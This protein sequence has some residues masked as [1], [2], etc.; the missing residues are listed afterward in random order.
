MHLLA[1]R[2]LSVAGTLC[3]I[4]I[5][6]EMSAS[7]GAKTMMMQDQSRANCWPIFGG[8][9]TAANRTLKLKSYLR[10][11]RHDRKRKW[12]TTD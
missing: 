1:Q 10:R 5:R 3:D 8:L 11:L 7:R 6:P 4:V 9:R 12:P 2:I